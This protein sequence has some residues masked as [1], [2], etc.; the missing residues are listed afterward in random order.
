MVFQL[1]ARS[2]RG[3]VVRLPLFPPVKQPMR[4]YFQSRNFCAQ[5]EYEV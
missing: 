1:V 5:L 2:V 3:S 4:G